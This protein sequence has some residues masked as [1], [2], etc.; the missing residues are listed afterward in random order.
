VTRVRK[1]ALDLSGTKV[2]VMEDEFFLA[3][4]LKEQIEDAGGTVLG[5]CMDVADGIA[6]LEAEPTC[7]IVDIN[8]G[9]GPSFEI[10]GELQQRDVPFFFLTGY[11]A[12]SIPPA[13]ASI[14]RIEKPAEASH[15]MDAVARLAATRNVG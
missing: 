13:F 15:V 12:P 5:P 9:H 1:P 3:F 6:Q 14:E 8:L 2:L 4:D 11:D 7:A 10:A